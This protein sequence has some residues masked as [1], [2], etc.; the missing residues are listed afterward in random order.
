MNECKI[1]IRTTS[2]SVTRSIT[3]D[4]SELSSYKPQNDVFDAVTCCNTNYNN[5]RIKVRQ[6]SVSVHIDI[7]LKQIIQSSVRNRNRFEFMTFSH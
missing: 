1:Y 7:V 2:D 5:R 4:N 6:D 3:K